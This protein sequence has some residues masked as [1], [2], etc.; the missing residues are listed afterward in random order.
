[1]PLHR[2]F[3]REEA[4]WMN[5][6]E[7]G[8]MTVSSL[9]VTGLTASVAIPVIAIIVLGI[10]RGFVDQT[11]FVY[12]VGVCALVVLLG[13]LTVN[14]FVRRKIQDRLLG[15]VDVCRNFAGG[16]RAVRATVPGEEDLALL[17]RSL[18]A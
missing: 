12:A 18:N 15:L 3:T 6:T 2:Y 7:R 16:D 9:L 11:A 13:V 5:D 10:L 4:W 8:G 17:S 1:M 14:Y